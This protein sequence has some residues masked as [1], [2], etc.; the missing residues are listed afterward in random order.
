MNAPILAQ[1]LTEE[2]T[3]HVRTL[4][5]DAIA[6]NRRGEGPARQQFEFNRFNLTLD[7]EGARVTLE[8]ELDTTSSGTVT[9]PLSRLV[10]ELQC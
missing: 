10:A 6:N 7:F 2:C 9:L 8:D 5:C 3:P 4:I 1:F